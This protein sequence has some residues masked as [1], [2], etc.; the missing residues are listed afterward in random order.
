MEAAA[1][2]R[3][4]VHRDGAMVGQH[5]AVH[6]GQTQARAL[7]GRLGGKEGFEQVDAGVGV[8][9]A[10]IIL[11]PQMG[12]GPRA[13]HAGPGLV[14]RIQAHG[15]PAIPSFQRMPGIGAQIHQHLLQLGGI[16]PHLQGLG[17]QPGLQLHAW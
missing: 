5:D 17:R 6:H 11:H 12:P 10:A 2:A 16:G 13:R 8:H 1:P 14:P 9:T 3:L 7:A 4:A 15:Q